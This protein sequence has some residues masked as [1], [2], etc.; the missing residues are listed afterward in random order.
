[1]FYQD[2][3]SLLAM[4]IKSEDRPSKIVCHK[5]GDETRRLDLEEFGERLRFAAT[6]SDS[7]V[8]RKTVFS[9]S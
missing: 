5:T 8:G 1:M 9:K 6:L 2:L 3:F 7:L 4:E